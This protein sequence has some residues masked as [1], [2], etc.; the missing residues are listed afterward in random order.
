MYSEGRWAGSR[1]H[2]L[3]GRRR[4][5]RLWASTWAQTLLWVSLLGSKPY[6]PHSLPSG[7]P[8]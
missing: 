3:K 8:Q 5:A 7:L 4:I 2:L 1:Y 6:P